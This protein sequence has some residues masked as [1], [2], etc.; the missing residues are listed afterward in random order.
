MCRSAPAHSILMIFG[1]VRDLAELIIGAKFCVDRF[2]GFRLI[3]GQNW[4][5]PWE[6]HELQPLGGHPP[7]MESVINLVAEMK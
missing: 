7:I 3:E 1:T 5:L 4:G 6:K 2:K